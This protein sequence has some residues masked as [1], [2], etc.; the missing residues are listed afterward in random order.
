MFLEED[1]CVSCSPVFVYLQRDQDGRAMGSKR[2]ID[3]RDELHE[4]TPVNY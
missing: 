3:K 2:Q 4:V 1:C